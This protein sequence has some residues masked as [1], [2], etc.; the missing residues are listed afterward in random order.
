MAV[1]AWMLPPVVGYST[2][3]LQ[4]AVN[5]LSAFNFA[6]LTAN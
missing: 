4:G 5:T 6:N 2:D 3:E 1:K